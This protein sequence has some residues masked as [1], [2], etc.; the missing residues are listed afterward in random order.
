MSSIFLKPEV[1]ASLIALLGVIL[2]VLLSLV[3]SHKQ[4]RLE[5]E[6]IE[7][8]IH[9]KYD[10]KLMNKR[11][12]CY[13]NLWELLSKFNKE[14]LEGKFKTGEMKEYISSVLS[15][16]EGWYKKN[17]IT[18]SKNA[19]FQ[20]SRLCTTLE[21]HIRKLQFNNPADLIKIRR[22]VWALRQTLHSNSMPSIITK[23]TL[24]TVR[25]SCQRKSSVSSFSATVRKKLPM[26]SRQRASG[27]T[28][29][30]LCW[31]R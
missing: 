17:G 5:L 7:K 9:A 3:V 12:T 29:V 11:L 26:C 28:S 25:W 20:F 16:L 30:E 4:F 27:A 22:R 2:S 10:E 21:S 24:L 14:V 8:I 13:R 19:Y 23:P 6:K 15:E 18:L 31:R 1:I